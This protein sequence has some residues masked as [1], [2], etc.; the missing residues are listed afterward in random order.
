MRDF[1]FL[2]FC[3]KRAYTM[4][5]AGRD[6]E[7]ASVS[8]CIAKRPDDWVKRWDF[9]R[10]TFWN[11]EAEAW[12]RV[13]VES[14]PEFKLFAYRILLLLFDT[15]GV[16]QPVTIDQFFPADMPELPRESAPFPFERIG[17]DVVVRD[18]LTGANHENRR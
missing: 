12:A 2:G 15:S 7:V 9:N 11:T 17:Y 6:R 1:V 16:E 5:L 14:K 13:L 10:A 18:V 8:E 4:W 3:A